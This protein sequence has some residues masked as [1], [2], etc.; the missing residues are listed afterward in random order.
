MAVENA[1]LLQLH[2]EINIDGNER[3]FTM[4]TQV[5]NE[6]KGRTLCKEALRGLNVCHFGKWTPPPT[7]KK[8]LRSTLRRHC[9]ED[10]ADDALHRHWSVHTF[11]Y[12]FRLQAYQY[13]DH[14]LCFESSTY[15]RMELLRRLVSHFCS[16]NSE[17]RD[18]VETGSAGSLAPALT[19]PDATC[20]AVD[21]DSDVFVNE[22]N[23]LP[24]VFFDDLGVQK[25]VIFYGDSAKHSSAVH[26]FVDQCVPNYSRHFDDAEALSF[27]DGSF[28]LALTFGTPDVI[29]WS[30]K[31]LSRVL[32]P[33][34]M[35]FNIIESVT[36]SPDA[37]SFYETGIHPEWPEDTAVDLAKT[38]LPLERLPL[39]DWAYR[40]EHS[41]FWEGSKQ[42]SA[43]IV[44]EIFKRI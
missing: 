7:G 41:V 42:P 24:Q 22:I 6:Q 16:G 11:P 38:R 21:V 26:A 29:L 14:G 2:H 37:L 19:F 3:F 9:A 40:L 25:P 30:I 15:V 23:H 27:A 28:D 17:L 13:A 34:A 31:E 35:L 5:L 33:G 12:H 4:N 1:V 18:I 39:P 8:I 10:V 44:I 32:R 20:V 43:G 36:R